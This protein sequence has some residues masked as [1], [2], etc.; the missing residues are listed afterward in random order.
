[1]NRLDFARVSYRT[2]RERLRTEDPEIDEVTLADTVEGL[3][4][5]HEIV[6]AILRS[7]LNN[8]AMASGLKQRIAEMQHRLERLSDQASKRRQIARDVML[9]ADIKKLSA[10]DFTASVRIGSSGVTI[11]AESSIPS[12]YWQPQKPR[13]D[14]QALLTALKNGAAIDGA[15]LSKPEPVISIRVK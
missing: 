14:R 6:A 2:I 12:I 11:L 4:D 9:E 13:L 7:A 15:Q 3:T 1:M 8:E 10:P 5:L